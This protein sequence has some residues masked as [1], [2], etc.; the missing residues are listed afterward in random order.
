MPVVATAKAAEAR[1]YWINAMGAAGRN[2]GEARPVTREDYQ[3]R[4]RA[5]AGGLFSNPLLTRAAQCAMVPRS[6]SQP[7]KVV[8]ISSSRSKT[9]AR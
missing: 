6:Y 5:L 8:A 3:D 4:L 1:V 9:N 2:N 7:A